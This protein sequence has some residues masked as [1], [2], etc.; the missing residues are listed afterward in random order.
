MKKLAIQ[1]S[2]NPCILVIGGDRTKLHYRA[3]QLA[4]RLGHPIWHIGP[5]DADLEISETLTDLLEND[6]E[7][8]LLIFEGNT[9]KFSRDT[10]DEMLSNFFWYPNLHRT[11]TILL[12]LTESVTQDQFYTPLLTARYHLDVRT[13]HLANGFEEIPCTESKWGNNIIRAR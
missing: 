2:D 1:C 9:H 12:V 3:Q 8:K 7:Q 11:R 10:G 5:Q 13:G 4:K 6:S